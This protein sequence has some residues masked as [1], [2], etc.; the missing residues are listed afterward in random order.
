MCGTARHTRIT[1]G[2][3]T[4]LLLGVDVP[5]PHTGTGSALFADA[6]DVALLRA[7]VVDPTGIVCSNASN[8]ITFRIVSGPGRVVGTH[9]G[10]ERD[11]EPNDVSWHSAHH[12]LVRGVIQVTVHSAGT[13]SERQR[14][15]EI[16][17]E[18]GRRTAVHVSEEAFES[19]GI[20]AEVMSPGLGSAR[21]TIPVSAESR[22]SVLETASR[23]I[24]AVFKSD[25]ESVPFPSFWF[26]QNAAS[27]DS[28]TE[29]ALVGKFSLAIYGWDHAVNVVPKGRQ[30]G[31]KLSEQCK[32]LKATGSKAHCAVYRQGWLGMANYDEQRAVLASNASATNDWWIKDNG[33]VPQGHHDSGVDMLFWNFANKSAA[34][35]Y[36]QKVIQPLTEDPNIDGVFFDDMPGNPHLVLTY[37]LPYPH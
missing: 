9:S 33:G 14:L 17:V 19:E 30:E 20:V 7:S 24:N 10:G 32:Q 2:S 3:P 5:S 11:H 35:Y 16:D 1:S 25:D 29:L 6:Q 27:M 15:M 31:E 8:N 18:G 12:G 21:V 4:T 28:A 23:S 36:Q 34:E 26:G 37:L 22:H 13:T